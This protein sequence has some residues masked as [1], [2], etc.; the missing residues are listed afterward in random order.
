M[1]TTVSHVWDRLEQID[2]L[3]NPWWRTFGILEV[4]FLARHGITAMSSDF[5]DGV[6]KTIGLDKV[7]G[8][9]K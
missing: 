9:G 4:H 7:L 3:R 5:N 1:G 6:L 8:T 2:R